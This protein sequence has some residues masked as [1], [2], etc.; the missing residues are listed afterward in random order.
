MSWFVTR[1]QKEGGIYLGPW[2]HDWVNKGHTNLNMFSVIGEKIRSLG[3]KHSKLNFWNQLH[4][5]IAFLC[6]FWTE[7]ATLRQFSHQLSKQFWKPW[8]TRFF[9]DQVTG[10]SEFFIKI[11][12]FFQRE[13]VLWGWLADP[14]LR[15][16][17]NFRLLGLQTW[18]FWQC[19]RHISM[20]FFWK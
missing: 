18:K 8:S 11:G 2:N 13:R 20:I 5:K 16:L 1:G 12:R 6:C 14:S 10:A 15:D 7:T 3:G 19:T 17:G 4:P 9:R